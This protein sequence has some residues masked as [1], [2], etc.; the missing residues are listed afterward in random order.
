[1]HRCILATIGILG[2]WLHVF[3][4]DLNTILHIPDSF[5]YLKMSHF[6]WEFDI[7]W[8]GSGWF[9]FL[10]ALPVA[11]FQL[12]VD[13]PFIAAQYTNMWLFLVSAWLMYRLG[14]LYLDKAY[15]YLLLILFFLSPALL[16]YNIHILS[17][18]IYIPL[19]LG[20]CLMLYKWW[21]DPT[22]GR[23]IGISFLLA[24]LYLTRWE[25]FIYLGAIYLI[26]LIYAFRGSISFWGI[27]RYAII[28]SL[29]F[30]IFVSPYVY[31]LYTKTGEIGL[32]NKWSSN[33]RQAQLRGVEH[34][35]D[36]W[37]EQAVAELTDDK[38]HLIAW[39]AGG[40]EYD[41]PTTSASLWEYISEN[42]WE[43]F[44]RFLT[45]QQKLYR[46]TLPKLLFG[47]QLRIYYESYQE[48]SFSKPL[49]GYIFFPIIFLLFGLYRM[50][51]TSIS[52][53][54]D[55]R[56][57]IRLYSALFIVASIFFTL[58]FVLERYFIVFLPLVFIVIC[59]GIQ[60]LLVGGNI[61]IRMSAYF[62][63]S[64]LL[65][66]HSWLGLYSYHMTHMWDD[67]QYKLK[68]T[69]GIWMNTKLDC[70]NHVC[71][72]IKTKDRKKYTMY[73]RDTDFKILERFPIVT[74]YSWSKHR[75]ITPYTS[76]LSDII[77]YAR[78]HK[79]DFLVVDTMDFMRYRPRL[80]FLLDETLTHTWLQVMK[81]WKSGDDK[82]IV[83]KIVY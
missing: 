36:S 62:I 64:I 46:D 22:M 45:N 80:S 49:L 18:N 67:D 70:Q 59:Y 5:A 72:E 44:E 34:M 27:F 77:E 30:I 79:I 74:Y 55:D 31:L 78:F 41:T 19:F 60:Y 33:L 1:M 42:R 71:E 14:S 2:I 35:D 9:W 15:V 10:Y 43:F 13:H 8:F 25:A 28:I 57:F 76:Q 11:L 12:F 24:L 23:S 56:S 53:I 68:Q 61:V 54:T 29:F 16:H 48:H 37:F 81:V 73:I 50:I 40:M 58:F 52:V 3:F 21:E 39:F 75:Y 69:V 47:N 83:Y 32:T 4:L 20:L 38:H 63:I 17:E 26:I 7:R 66:L 82:V 6:I 51:F 65:I